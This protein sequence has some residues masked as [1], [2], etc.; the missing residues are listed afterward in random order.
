M[1]EI[2]AMRGIGVGY[3]LAA[4]ALLTLTVG[5][6]GTAYAAGHFPRFASLAAG[7]VY[8]R[9]GPS[10]KHRILWVYH[11][12]DLPVEILDEYADWRRVK[13]PSGT[14]GWIHSA[15]LSSKRTVVVMGNANAPL[16]DGAGTG[17]RVIAYA[18]PGVVARLET[19][20]AEACE[21]RMAGREGWIDRTR[22]WGAGRTK[23]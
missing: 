17:R 19:C 4:L 16:R 6:V 3:R 13:M 20:T 18:Q 12:K 22:I 2:P 11:R 5:G 1:R 9:Q 10:Y 15:M 14:V 8:L 21:V 23:K 7:K